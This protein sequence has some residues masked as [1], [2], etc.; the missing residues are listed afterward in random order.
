M[1]TQE[2]NQR[3]GKL[4]DL[5]ILVPYVKQH[6]LNLWLSIALM[7]ISSVISIALP[8]F[9]RRAVDVHIMGY[10]LPGL[11]LLTSIAFGLILVTT[12]ANI[13]RGRL[14]AK[15]GQNSIRALRDDLFAYMQRLPVKFFDKIPVGKLITRLTSDVDAL[16]DL[17]GNAIVSMVIDTLRL[18]GFLA[19]MFWL[20]WRLTLI[21]LTLAPIL[22]FAL[23]FLT[24]RIRKAEDQVREQASLVNANLQESISGIRV[25]QGFQAEDYFHEQFKIEDYNLLRAGMR[26]VATYAYFWPTIDLSWLLST[27][28]IFYFGGQWVMDGTATPGDLVAFI[29]YTGQFFGPL[30]GLSQAYRIIQRALAGAVRIKRIMATETEEK[31]NLNPMPRITGKVEFENITFGY[32]PEEIVLHDIS[33]AAEPGQ[34]IA[35]VGHTGAGKTSIINLLCRFYNPIQ[36]RILVDGLD[37]HEHELESYRRQIGLVLQEPFLFSGT[38]RDNIRFGAPE[39]TDEQIWDALETVGLAETFTKSHVTLDTIL[40]ER[41]ANFS[42]GQRQLISFARAL[43]SDPRI[44]IL[45]EATAHVDTLTEQKVQQALAKLLAGRT[46]FVIAHRLSTI[47]NAD[48]IIVIGDGHILERGTHEQLLAQKGEYWQLCSSQNM[49]Q[50]C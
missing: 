21:T 25:I 41:G 24:A 12:S 37:I 23:T 18:T 27:A 34:T 45:D 20:D 5:L 4:R 32:D 26:A 31:A 29:A 14:M 2:S 9:I 47:R 8:M 30:R 38:L 22:V 7:I 39:A 3:E 35:L 10:D 28:A 16:R 17:V 42:T 33:F 43:I 6:Q 44:L 11:L 13:F 36:G 50:I 15:L 49:A 46:S 40:T 48:L 19:L 1:T